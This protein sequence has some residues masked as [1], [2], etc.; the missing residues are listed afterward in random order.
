ML[1]RSTGRLD[2]PD[3]N[4]DT[5]TDTV[6]ATDPKRTSASCVA[7][8]L[9]F[10]RYRRS[11]PCLIR[12]APSLTGV[13]VD[14]SSSLSVA[15]IDV[16]RAKPTAASTEWTVVEQQEEVD[17]EQGQG[18]VAAGAEESVDSDRLGRQNV[19]GAGRFCA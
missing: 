14:G 4:I 5:D 16:P 9:P 8:P 18:S 11:Y 2:V 3:D 6:L 7:L 1:S 19:R 15:G 13:N 12:R 17:G 10:R